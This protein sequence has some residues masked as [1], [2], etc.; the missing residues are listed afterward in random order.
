[1]PEYRLG[2]RVTA[3][4]EGR[5]R[6]GIIIAI[7]HYELENLIEGDSYPYRVAHD[8]TQCRYQKL[9]RQEENFG[10]YHWLVDDVSDVYAENELTDPIRQRGDN[11]ADNTDPV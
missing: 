4:M 5:V 9:V 8:L 10:D 6:Q 3:T 2:E 11:N 1:M 7:D